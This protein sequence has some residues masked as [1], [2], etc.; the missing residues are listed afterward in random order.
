MIHRRH[1]AP[2]TPRI[3]NLRDILLREHTLS[4][5]HHVAHRTGIHKQNLT[6]TVHRTI[7]TGRLILRQQPHTRRGAR[8][9]KHIRRQHQHSSHRVALNHGATNTALT[10]SI[11][12]QRTIRH[13]HSSRTLHIQLRPHVLQP[14][15]ISVILR[16]HTKHPAQ[17]ILNPMPF[18]DIE[19]RVRQHVIKTLTRVRILSER[20]TP[21]VTHRTINTV[22][23]QVQARQTPGRLVTLLTIRQHTLLTLTAAIKRTTGT[24]HKIIRL[25]KHTARTAARIIHAT[26]HRLN[27]THQS[28]HHSRRGV[29]LAT[30]LALRTSKLTQ[31]ILIH[32]T[33]NIF[34]RRM[35]TI[36]HRREIR[37]RQQV[38]HLRQGAL[39]HL[40]A[41]IHGLKG[42]LQRRVL[43]HNLIHRGV[44]KLTHTVTLRLLHQVRPAGTN[45]HI[46]CMTSMV[47][48][49]LLQLLS[50][51]L[52]LKAVLLSQHVLNILASLIEGVTNVLQED[53]AQHEVA[54]TAGLHG[55][56]QNVR[57]L[58]QHLRQLSRSSRGTRPLRYRRF[59]HYCA[60]QRHRGWTPDVLNVSV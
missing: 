45:R 47:V 16:R 55:T 14:R 58:P 54:V 57:G 38:N 37:I 25:H 46:E 42:T 17:V 5:R 59:R 44:N 1:T 39:L 33:Q 22:N 15:K 52:T 40:L 34:R 50:Q 31:E 18:L 19:R 48:R 60:F 11:S 41:R 51:S 8:R 49:R 2:R 53:Q 35:L 30:L 36:T 12:S 9:R 3:R 26:A 29:E 56:A 10:T 21:A 24:V 7:H 13:H 23:R 28:V 4:T 43:S 20:I 27:H 32:E 6:R